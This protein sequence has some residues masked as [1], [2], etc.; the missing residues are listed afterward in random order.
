MEGGH[1]LN[2]SLFQTLFSEIAPIFYGN[3]RSIES[4]DLPEGNIFI[5]MYRRYYP[6][7]PLVP[8]RRHYFSIPTISWPYFHLPGRGAVDFIGSLHAHVLGSI[9]LF[10]A[11]Q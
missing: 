10:S 5:G 11:L 3:V 1:D 2:S 9:N 4:K 6:N 7:Q 8:S